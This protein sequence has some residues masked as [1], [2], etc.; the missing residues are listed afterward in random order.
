MPP[1]F[2]EPGQRINAEV[3]LNVLETVI[4][5]WITQVAAGRPYVFQQDGA[6]AHTS[7]PVQSWLHNN[8]PEFWPKDLW[9]PYSPDLNPLDYYVWSV[10]ERVSNKRAHTDTQTLTVAIQRAFADLPRE[11]LKKACSSFRPRLEQVIE[12]QG[13]WIE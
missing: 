9:P 7:N 13:F 1:H 6:P 10:I 8:V 2:F 5:P 3:Y 4:K 11:Q 12:A